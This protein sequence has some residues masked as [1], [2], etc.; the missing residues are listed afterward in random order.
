MINQ[1]FQR[2]F[3]VV[4]WFVLTISVVVSL[5]ADY[6]FA[7][8]PDVPGDLN[9]DSLVTITDIQCA[10]LVVLYDSAGDEVKAPACAVVGPDAADLDCDFQVTVVDAVLIIQIALSG[11]LGTGVDLNANGCTDSCETECPPNTPCSVGQACKHNADCAS[12]WEYCAFVG[13]C[14]DNG[15][16]TLRP[17]F[18]PPPG[19][20]VCGCDGQSWVSV[21]K[22]ASNGVSVVASG[23]CP[24]EPA[25][26]EPSF[27]PKLSAG[28]PTLLQGMTLAH[29]LLRAEVGAP[30][31]TWNPTL[32][33]LAQGWANQCV[34][35]YDSARTTKWKQATGAKT[36]FVGQLFYVTDV[37]SV[38]PAISSPFSAWTA[39]QQDY[40]WI[41]NQCASGQ[42]CGHYTQVIWATTTYLGC[43]IKKCAQL[44]LGGITWTGAYIVVCNYAVGGNY[45]G[46][47]PYPPA[48]DPCVDLDRDGIV[49]MEDCNDT[50]AAVGTTA[51]CIPAPLPTDL[52]GDGFSPPVDCDD[53]NAARR[54]TAVEVPDDLDNDC[55]GLIDE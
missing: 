1:L 53:A 18:C 29:N 41:S 51:G 11:K 7:S 24:T 10:L 9:K 16:C 19:D 49:Q 23:A 44:Q 6:S 42:N 4:K 2:V 33:E 55:D 26:K 46:V 45:P 3:A 17:D 43:G 48:K 12:G 54:P 13:S 28:E 25:C 50:N 40:T 34:A 31:V 8:C 5:G 14:G 22:A 32:A 47:W 21:C 39:G 52:D 37:D 20:P 36:P 35:Q 15:V 38:P 27:D 30:P